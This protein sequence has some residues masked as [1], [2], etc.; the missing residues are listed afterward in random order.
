MGLSKCIKTCIHHCMVIHSSFATLKFTHMHLRKPGVCPTFYE[1]CPLVN[2]KV[3]LIMKLSAGKL[4]G[5][6]STYW[7]KKIWWAWPLF[8]NSSVSQHIQCHTPPHAFFTSKLNREK[9]I[10]VAF[11]WQTSEKTNKH[12]ALGDKSTHWSSSNCHVTPHPPFPPK[13][14]CS[15]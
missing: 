3:A 5:L 8:H 10:E 12:E 2:P 9:L 11:H 15:S 6:S 7:I 4:P 1:G 14:W 13:P